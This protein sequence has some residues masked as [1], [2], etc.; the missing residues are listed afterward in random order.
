M[1]R[2]EH[3]LKQA[4]QKTLKNKPLQRGLDCPSEQDLG[5]YLDR[6]LPRAD[7]EKIEEHLAKCPL[8]LDLIVVAQE[9]VSSTSKKFNVKSFLSKQK[10]LLVALVSF[11]CSFIFS[12]YFLQFLVITLIFGIKWAIGPEGARNLVMIF[13]SMHKEEERKDTKQDTKIRR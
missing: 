5:L 13:R 7:R 12:R 2:I 11:I 8:C 1:S 9:A 6:G 3:I 10:W 4:L